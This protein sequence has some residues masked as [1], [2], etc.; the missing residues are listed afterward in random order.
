VNLRILVVSALLLTLLAPAA[1]AQ[2]DN[3]TA[4]APV[5]RIKRLHGDENK[6]GLLS[7]VEYLNTAAKRFDD[8]DANDDGNITSNE[9]AAYDEARRIQR[10]KK[11]A[12]AG[13]G[14]TRTDSPAAEDKG[15]L[16]RFFN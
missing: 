6:D 2:T 8:I 10:E 16:N 5:Q 14:K 4:K 3:G 12:R 9:Q 13:E 15:F 11:K 7:K 1:Y